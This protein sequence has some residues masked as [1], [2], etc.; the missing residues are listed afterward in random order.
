MHNVSVFVG[1]VHSVFDWLRHGVYHD[2]IGDMMKM[3]VIIDEQ[4]G[5][6]HNV[7]SVPDSLDYE[8]ARQDYYDYYWELYRHTGIEA[9]LVDV[10]GAVICDLPVYAA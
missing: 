1:C 9:Y 10:Y 5:Q 2:R 4:T 7:I 3:I 8:K 6:F